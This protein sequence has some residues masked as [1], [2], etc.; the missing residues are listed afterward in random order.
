MYKYY[1]IPKNK[2]FIITHHTK[3]PNSS[4]KI[5]IDECINSPCK[6]GADCVNIPGS[7]KCSCPKGYTTLNNNECVD[8]NECGRANS[9]GANA[10]CINVPGSYKCICPPGF[11]GQGELHCQS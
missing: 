1:K 4:N 7:F 5:D 6:N 3:T 11:V 10:K 8:I 2:K 9:C